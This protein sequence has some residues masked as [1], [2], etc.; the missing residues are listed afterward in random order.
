MADE[1]EA[2]WDILNDMVDSTP[3]EAI[4]QIREKKYVYGFRGKPAEESKYTGRI[5]A[6]GIAYDRKT[7]KHTCKTEVLREK[8]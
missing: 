1:D 8:V 6:V 4:R 7:K 2:V 5:L 3:E